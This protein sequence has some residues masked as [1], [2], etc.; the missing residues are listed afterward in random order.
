MNETEIP[1]L[2]IFLECK[3]SFY[4]KRF[5]SQVHR[6]D[7]L[8]TL[9][10]FLNIPV[11]Q[12]RYNIHNAMYNMYNPINKQKLYISHVCYMNAKKNGFNTENDL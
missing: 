4:P 5:F 6:S 9:N 3:N 2:Y 10:N 1:Y 11:T 7:V 8:P 12:I